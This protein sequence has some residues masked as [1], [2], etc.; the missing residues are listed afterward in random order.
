MRLLESGEIGDVVEHERA[1]ELERALERELGDPPARRAEP[2]LP[3]S[4]TDPPGSGAIT[5]TPGA[6]SRSCSGVPARIGKVP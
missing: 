3:H 4:S 6:S 5:S 1:L 2:A